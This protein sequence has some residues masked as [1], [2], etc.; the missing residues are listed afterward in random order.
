VAEVSMSR[1]VR[2]AV[3]SLAC[4]AFTAGLAIE[5]KGAEPPSYL[6]SFGP[7]GTEA[8]GFAGPGPIAVD[9]ET[10]LVY[11][12]NH[13]AGS[14]LKFDLEG[15][16][17]AFAGSAEYISGNAITGLA[18]FGGAGETQV[19]VDF[20]NHNL[21]VTSGDA[22]KAFQDDGDPYEFSA[23]PGAGTNEI[24]GFSELLG[25]AVDASGNIY[26]ADYAG[27]VRIYSPSGAV[28]TQFEASTAANIAVDGSGAVYVNR[29][30]GTVTKFTPSEFPVTSTTTYAEA[31]GP[32]DS[33]T[34]YTVT[35]DP[36]TN[37]V[38]IAENDGLTVRIA[39]Y[40]ESGSLLFTFGG[41]GEE[42]ELSSS[43]GVG[44]DGDT[45]TIYVSNA[46]VSGLSQVE[47]FGPEVIVTGP[48]TIVSTS[49]SD[50]TGSSAILHGEINPNTFQTTYRFEFGT[51]DC[52]LGG[53]A[54]LPAEGAEIGDGHAVV[55]VSNYLGEL[56][57]GTTY[58]YRVVAENSA[59][60]IEGPERTFTTQK[61]SIGFSLG[62]GRVWEMISPP[63]KHG[64]A[65]VADP[66]GL[67]Q[68]SETGN[69]LAYLTR[70]SIEP[71]PE[72][73]R[74]IELST[75]LAS[76]QNGSWSSKDIT[77]PHTLATG[78]RFGG[79]YKLF[80]RNLGK[81]VLEPRDATHLSPEASER[82]PYL[83]QNTEPP[84]YVALVHGGNVPAGTEFGK[85]ER[86]GRSPVSVSGANAD[87]S[88]VILASKV[89]LVA[90][91]EPFSLYEW[92]D[93]SLDPVSELPE[94]E[95]GGIVLAQLGS[96]RGSIRNA[97]S[98]DGSRVFWSPT[99]EYT[100]AGIFLP[101]LYLRDTVADAT[102]RLDVVEP[103][104][105][106]AGPVRPAFQGASVDGRV[107]FFTDSQQLTKDA[108]F[109]GRDL[110]RCEIGI[111]EEQ[112]AC[113]D[114]TDISAPRGG[115]GESAEV[116]DLVS[117][118]SD[119]GKRLYFVAGAILDEAPNE[120]GDAAI[121]GEPNLYLWEEERGTRFIAT[122]S[123]ADSTAWGATA[124]QTYGF[125]AYLAAD[126]SPSGR[127][128]AFMSE[129]SLT[130]Y[131]NRSTSSGARNEHAY[132]YDAAG[133]ELACV[134]C[135][136]TGARTTGR[137]LPPSIESAG[138]LTRL[139]DPH[140]LWAER[141]VAATLPEAGEGETLGWS[142][143]HPRTV[144]N[145]GRVFFN[146][147]DELVPGDANGQWDVYQY[148]PLGVG[149]CTTNAGKA[150][151]TSG[152]GCVG[153]LSS[154]AAEGESAF[155]DASGSGDDV[156]FLTRG[157]LSI[158]DKDSAL[159]VYDARVGGAPAV[160]TPSRECAGEACQPRA[161]SPVEQTPASEAFQG[162]SDPRRC[163]KGKRKIRR[164]GKVQCVRRHT[165]RKHKKHPRKRASKSG[166]AQS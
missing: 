133:D 114:L 42:G 30:H 36:T 121:S 103:D 120:A 10:D 15:N 75:V 142:F 71:D 126:S 31:A 158:L 86:A 123:S 143:Y 57:A 155:L 80:S 110:Y 50:V 137:Q 130:G 84:Q 128:Y 58:H 79:E 47:I 59:G 135:D 118:I 72:G 17:V 61:A 14:L 21:Y 40:D 119:D 62:D 101:G 83:R 20:S 41:A 157:R 132:L 35:V 53:C 99:E 115:S 85:I 49:V 163:P 109:E 26:T 51:A 56:E 67:I 65:V 166:R 82:T 87:L 43:E 24:G 141:W 77:P 134:S 5:A 45:G 11:V 4:F 73:N 38:Y 100:A 146:S 97:V 161:V 32:L 64:G 16:P 66:L 129:Q 76:R 91:A 55:A 29:W 159:D 112:P 60:V 164:H 125:G 105:S 102:T 12:I 39:V 150:A 95:G 78:I 2:V 88:H 90:G 136:P 127:F 113:A 139:A 27:F 94:S 145:N 6:G 111:V 46:P 74:A 8:T 140:D 106:G 144:L 81:A 147:V 25:V 13:Q 122:L 104:A 63:N 154:G 19:A 37:D 89:P 44:V 152:N 108:S 148:E 3:A 151:V 156:F 48:P 69:G 124:T 34:S 52:A 1:W 7:D 153:L 116:R 23:G 9:Q 160:A 22:V 93:G 18:Y 54:S 131:D 68:A 28:L 107:V 92:A 162:P 33:A 98:D 138:S 70:G 165:H 96:G 117:A 149:G